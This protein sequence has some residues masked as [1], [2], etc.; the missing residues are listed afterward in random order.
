MDTATTSTFMHCIEIINIIVKTLDPRHTQNLRSSSK[1]F[2][3]IFT[4]NILKQNV[5]D[6]IAR[7]TIAARLPNGALC[8]HSSLGVHTLSVVTSPISDFIFR[9]LRR[10]PYGPELERAHN[11]ML[12]VR[13]NGDAYVARAWAGNNRVDGQAPWPHAQ[14][15]MVFGKTHELFLPESTLLQKLAG[16][17]WI[18]RVNHNVVWEGSN[19]TCTT[20]H[21]TL[22]KSYVVV[23][24]GEFKLQ[25]AC[26]PLPV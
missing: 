8:L 7:Y 12:L 16:G 3:A 5:Q 9:D 20:I 11:P 19:H 25:L 10:L 18:S 22:H 26:I 2:A 13:L 24:G 14:D 15:F 4:P 21:L 23:S 17:A 6:A 1:Q